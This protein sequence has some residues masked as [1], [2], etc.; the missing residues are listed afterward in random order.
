[1]SPQPTDAPQTKAQLRKAIRDGVKQSIEAR[2]PWA[3]GLYPEL[4]D[5]DIFPSKAKV[6]MLAE[7]IQ[8]EPDRL[9]NLRL[10]IAAKHREKQPGYQPRKVG[11]LPSDRRTEPT[12]QDLITCPSCGHNFKESQR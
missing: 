6:V 2:Y 1:M 10:H 12:K 8:R 9:E 3:V 11:P 5:T 7:Q 4:A